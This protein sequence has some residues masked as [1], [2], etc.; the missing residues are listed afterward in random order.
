M[1]GRGRALG[2][3]AFFF[4]QHWRGLLA[5]GPFFLKWGMVPASAGFY[6]FRRR[7]HRSAYSWPGVSSA[8]DKKA[9][10]NA[11]GAFDVRLCH[12]Y[13]LH[14]SVAIPIT[15]IDKRIL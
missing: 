5:R 1:G 8:E 14:G 15:F 10:P 2:V 7:A 3:T 9:A 13:T 11:N 12:G 6:G 4:V